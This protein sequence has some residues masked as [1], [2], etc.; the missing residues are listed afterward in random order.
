MIPS[1]RSSVIASKAATSLR[2]RE[3][4]AGA[5]PRLARCFPSPRVASSSIWSSM[6]SLRP[7]RRAKNGLQ[8]AVAILAANITDNTTLNINIDHSDTGSGAAAGLA[9]G[10]ATGPWCGGWQPN[11]RPTSFPSSPPPRSDTTR[12]GA[13]APGARCAGGED[14]SCDVLI[15]V[16]ADAGAM[17]TGTTAS[18]PKRPS[19][20]YRHH[21][22]SKL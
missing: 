12:L 8:Q 2:V 1:T 13:Q 11:Q 10:A 21:V 19:R 22:N 14:A 18:P 5:P 20:A 17:S 9:I 15:D 6:R 4:A 7:R 3:A 16:G